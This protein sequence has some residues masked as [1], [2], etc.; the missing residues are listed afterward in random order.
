MTIQTVNREKEKLQGC[1]EYLKLEAGG[2]KTYAHVFM[3][4]SA[5]YWLLLERLWQKGVKLEK[6]ERANG[7]ME[8]EILDPGDERRWVLVPT[9]KRVGDR[10]RNGMLVV[11]GKDGEGQITR[12]RDDSLMEVVL[13]LS[14]IYDSVTQC[15]VYKRVAVKV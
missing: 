8:V 9:K 5:L 13:T 14:F 12:G 2:V 4:Q 7:S 15:L 10:L 3:V 11:R 1:M 6:I